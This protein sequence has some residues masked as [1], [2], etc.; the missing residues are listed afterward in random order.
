MP[1]ASLILWAALCLGQTDLQPMAADSSPSTPSG[2]TW[3]VAPEQLA[4]LSPDMQVRSISEAVKRVEPGDTVFI[5][6]GVYRESVTVDKSGTPERPIRFVAAAGEHVTITGADELAQWQ[7]EPC[8]TNIF[9]TSWPHRFIGWN[10][11]TRTPTTM[12][13]R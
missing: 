12:I 8:N 9:S 11:R 3:H 6:A 7:R 1:N 10:P 2:R 13:T 4:G 5:H